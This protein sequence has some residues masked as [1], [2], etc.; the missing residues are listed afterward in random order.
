MLINLAAPAVQG[1]SEDIMKNAK[2]ELV[3]FLEENYGDLDKF[4][5]VDLHVT[6]Y[7]FGNDEMFLKNV[8][9]IGDEEC[10]DG[11]DFYQYVLQ[12]EH[13]YKAY[14]DFP[15]EENDEI[16]YSTAYKIEDCTNEILEIC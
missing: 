8:K 9:V 15:V 7:P 3:K 1:E 11:N 16:D 10:F 5:E 4:L 12:G 6:E 14:Y 13:L 2:L